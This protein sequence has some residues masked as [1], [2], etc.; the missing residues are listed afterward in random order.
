MRRITLARA[1]IELAEAEVAVGDEPAHA[2]LA[3]ARQGLLAAEEGRIGDV[4]DIGARLYA[5]IATVEAL[6][7]ERTCRTCGREG[8]LTDEHAP[9][10][11]A[12]NRGPFLQGA[13]DGEQ[14]VASGRMTWTAAEVAAAGEFLTFGTLAH[15]FARVRCGE[16]A[17]ERWSILD[18]VLMVRERAART[19]ARTE[20]PHRASARGRC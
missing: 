8:A 11:G 4:S 7:N 5:E 18:A 3:G 20:D 17:F 1:A 10:R 19:A 2:E 12:G 14:S 16:R 6:G 13:I 15:G 9:S